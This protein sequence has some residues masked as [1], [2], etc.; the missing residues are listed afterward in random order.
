MFCLSNLN[1]IRAAEN[2]RL[3]ILNIS[4]IDKRNLYIRVLFFEGV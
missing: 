2:A 4:Y 1:I 3:I